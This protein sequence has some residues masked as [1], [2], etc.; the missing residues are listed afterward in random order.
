MNV[1]PN[2]VNEINAIVVSFQ[3]VGL[4]RLLGF[5]VVLA[6]PLVGLRR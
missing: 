6:T 1:I 2:E 4:R 5:A 3:L